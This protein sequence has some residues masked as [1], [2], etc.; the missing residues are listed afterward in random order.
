MNMLRINE[1]QNLMGCFL[2]NLQVS[3]SSKTKQ[4]PNR[5][6]R[7]FSFHFPWPAGLQLQ[8]RTPRLRCCSF[9]QQP[10]P[11]Q[12]QPSSSP[13]HPTPAWPGLVMLL[14]SLQ[15][16]TLLQLL[17]SLRRA[18]QGSVVSLVRTEVNTV[19][20]LTVIQ[21]FTRRSRRKLCCTVAAYTQQ[22]DA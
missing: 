12:Q 7:C 4:K 3:S 14:G 11:S 15:R 16:K 22:H 19:N 1:T 21:P 17:R 18:V 8:L 13:L 5:R 20:S 10:S 2:Y 6:H 9:I